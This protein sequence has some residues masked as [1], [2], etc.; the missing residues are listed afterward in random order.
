MEDPEKDFARWALGW[1]IDVGITDGTCPDRATA[2]DHYLRRLSDL[3]HERHA[4][5]EREQLASRLHALAAGVSR[6]RDL[7]AVAEELAVL[8]VEVE[9]T[10]E[11]WGL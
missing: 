1:A 2:L 4:A 5:V 9:R 10:E 11:R 7:L 3:Q 8:S 6:G